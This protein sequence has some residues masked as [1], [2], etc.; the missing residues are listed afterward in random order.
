MNKLLKLVIIIPICIGCKKYEKESDA[1][2]GW[3]CDFSIITTSSTASDACV[4]EGAI[5]VLSPKGS[6]FLYSINNGSSQSFPSF[7][8]LLPGKYQ[9]KVISAAGCS[10]TDSV[11]VLAK[12]VT[13]GSKF[14]AVKTVF[15]T[16]CTPCHFS[17]SPSGGISL[18]S[19]CQIIAAWDRIKA[20]AVDGISSPMPQGGLIPLI[21]R[22]KISDWIDAGHRMTD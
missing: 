8:S 14:L 10:K 19:N 6:G 1:T 18:A 17:F 7:V 16:Y 4:A 12:Q 9:I 13:L 5:N 22:Q 2:N 3:P 20:R 11:V 15:N 21:E